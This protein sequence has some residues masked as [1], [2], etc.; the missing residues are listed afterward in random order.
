MNWLE[1]GCVC[2]STIRGTN[3]DFNGYSTAKKVLRISVILQQWQNWPCRKSQC[4]QNLER[5]E[6]WISLWHSARRGRLGCTRQACRWGKAK[7]QNWVCFTAGEG[8]VSLK[9]LIRGWWTFD[10]KTS[11]LLEFKIDQMLECH[12]KIPQA[13]PRGMNNMRRFSV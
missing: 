7:P 2:K 6:V 5:Q 8:R 10:I 9:C 13:S 11:D 4:R 1:R 3:I 12:C